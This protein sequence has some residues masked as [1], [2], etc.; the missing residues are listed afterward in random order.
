MGALAPAGLAAALLGTAAP[1]TVRCLRSDPL[2]GAAA[3][4]FIG[5]RALGLSLGLLQGALD[6]AAGRSRR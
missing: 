5:L 6:R 4:L 3:P 1:L 2:V